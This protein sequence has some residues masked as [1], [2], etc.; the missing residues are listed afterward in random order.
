MKDYWRH[1][2]GEDH[3]IK[4]FV[5]V[6]SNGVYERLRCSLP[7]QSR[8]LLMK[9]NFERVGRVSVTNPNHHPATTVGFAVL[10]PTYQLPVQGMRRQ[11]LN[12]SLPIA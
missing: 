7:T 6:P 9:Q 1:H 8:H 3:W 12:S 5:T 2:V 11:Q 4:D 10:I